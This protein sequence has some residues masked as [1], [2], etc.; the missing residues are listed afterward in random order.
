MSK[1]A[2][3]VVREQ[4]EAYPYP[5]RDA[6][7]EKK[8]LISGSPSHR[9]EINHYCFGG[10]RDFTKPFRAL[11]AG[12]GTGDGF[13]MLAQQLADIGCPAEVVHLDISVAAQAVAK[14]RAEARGLNNVR[15]VQGSLLDAA[16][17]APGPWDYID[18]CGVL[19][20]L[21]DPAAGL[22][23]LKA[24]LA[25]DGG[26]GLMVYGDLGRTGVYPLQAAL[27]ALGG[28]LGP[29]ARIAQAKK[30][31]ATLPSTNWFAANLSLIHI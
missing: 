9:D 17:V 22:A 23:A 21:A 19:H 30:L 31:L 4:Y 13:I 29:V 11:F 24:Q 26:M 18:C 15:F 6:A 7:D 1:S 28:D 2:D 14:A 25:D 27:R 3:E 5:A 10:R 8:R 20:H 12:G 16:D